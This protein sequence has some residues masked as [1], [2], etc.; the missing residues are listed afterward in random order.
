MN[1]NL[2]QNDRSVS[3]YFLFALAFLGFGLAGGGIILASP[4]LALSGL[5]VM[6]LAFLGFSLAGEP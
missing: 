5:L 6:L 4:F 2:N 3:D 1:A